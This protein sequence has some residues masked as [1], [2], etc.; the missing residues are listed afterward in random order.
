VRLDAAALPLEAIPPAPKAPPPPAPP[1][2]EEIEARDWTAVRSGRDQAALQAF[3][4]K[5]PDSTH[6]AEAQR[7]LAQLEWDAVDR[8]DRAALE[9]FAARYRGTPFAEPAN[10]EIAR[11]DRES[12]AAAAA[13]ANAAAAKKA[14]EQAGADRNEI[15]RVLATYATAFEK[16]DLQLLKSVWPGLPESTLA[17]AFRGRGQVRSQLR[18]LAPP[19]LAGDHA[20]VRC[21]RITEQATQFGRQKPLEEPRTVHLR[22]ES[23]RWIISAID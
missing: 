4:Q 9:R 1:T 2:A 3:L 16:K 20:S 23:G 12:S 22:K 13:A 18:A 6:K 11:L 10:A 19:E 14:E 5:H 8:K 7:M 21:T 17:D 15:A